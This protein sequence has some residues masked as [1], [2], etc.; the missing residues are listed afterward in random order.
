METTKEKKPVVKKDKTAAAKREGKAANKATKVAATKKTKEDATAS[1]S[2]CK[3][4]ANQ[5]RPISTYEPT[6]ALGKHIH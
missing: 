6:A 4:F 5:I 1:K 3:Y 2:K